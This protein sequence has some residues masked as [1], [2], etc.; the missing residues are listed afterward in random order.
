MHEAGD[1]EGVEERARRIVRTR[2]G[3]ERVRAREAEGPGAVRRAWSDDWRRTSRGKG[4][5]RGS[6]RAGGLVAPLRRR[7]RVASY[8]HR[9]TMAP[10]P[11]REDDLYRSAA[12]YDLATALWSGGAIWRTRAWCLEGL[13]PE[14]RVHPRTG[15]R[16]HGGPGRGARR[17]R[18]RCREIPRHASPRAAWI[19]RAGRTLSWSSATGR[20][21]P[22][23]GPSTSSWP[24]TSSTCSTRRGALG[25]EAL[26]RRVAA[27]GA[28][29]SPT[30]GRWSRSPRPAPAAPPPDPPGRLLAAHAERVHPSTITAR[31]SR[32]DPTCGRCSSE[33]R[34]VSCGPRV[35]PGVD[36]R[37]S[38]AHE[39]AAREHQH[40][41]GLTA[42]CA[43]ALASMAALT[44]F[45][46]GSAPSPATRR[47]STR[48]ST[49]TRRSSRTCSVPTAHRRVRPR[50]RGRARPV[51]H[52][53]PSRP[54]SR[55]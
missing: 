6:R 9:T 7:P 48:R 3:E 37:R 47:R 42:A 4:V 13:R 10:P 24:S 41:A 26:I 39:R 28:S 34:G 52:P 46:A 53:R 45:R 8:H 35:V 14:E 18:P 27:A 30:S 19:E 50:R 36:T 54:C 2:G 29:R 15:L 23:G 21:R 17:S 51:P 44:M 55:R 33:T 43:A 22:R 20:R 1:R 40:R 11:T 12:V 38:G 16:P 31:T 25:R 32:T 49:S 5:H